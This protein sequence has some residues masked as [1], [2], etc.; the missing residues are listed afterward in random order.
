[1]DLKVTLLGILMYDIQAK[2]ISVCRRFVS[3]TQSVRIWSAS[4]KLIYYVFMVQPKTL[5][6]R[7]TSSLTLEFPEGGL[8]RQR[9]RW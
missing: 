7:N 8:Q 9:E 2:N 4:T 1:M 5:L 6:H 3:P